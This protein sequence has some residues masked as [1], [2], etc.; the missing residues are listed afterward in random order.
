MK[1]QILDMLKCKILRGK[2]QKAVGYMGMK[3]RKEVL[4]RETDQK[5]IKYTN[6]SEKDFCKSL[7]KIKCS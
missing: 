5:S 2:M 7:A 4:A 1:V 6:I 3:P